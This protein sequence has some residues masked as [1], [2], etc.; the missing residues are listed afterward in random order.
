MSFNRRQ[1]LTALFAIAAASPA[2][3]QS[4]V[5]PAKPTLADVDAAAQR[6]IELKATPGVQICVR[7]KGRAVYSK[8]FGAANLEDGAKLTPQSICKIGSVTKQ[9]T[10]SLIL[11]LAE[12]GKLT[13]DDR[14]AK[15]FPDFPRAADVSLRRMLSHTSGLGNYTN[16]QRLAVAQIFRTD[17]DAA[18]IV[19]MMK[20]SEGQ[21]F[22]P[23]TAYAYSNT[24]Y[25]LLGL[26]AEKVG[27]KPYAEQARE[28]LW[29]PA[30]L[31]RTAVDN[32]GEMLPGRAAGYSID[33]NAPSGFA[34]AAYISMTVP[35]GAGFLRSTC[36]DLCLWEEALLGGKILKPASLEAMLTPAV[37]ND[38]GIPKDSRGRE[39]RYGFGLQLADT[40]GRRC[41]SHGGGIPGFISDLRNYPAEGVTIASIFNTD[42]GQTPAQ[43][44]AISLFRVTLNRAALATA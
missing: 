7:T 12:D 1:S 5:V 34:N 42:G 41:I 33:P 17:Y 20:G 31:T 22:E 11:L 37:T 38:G 24:A 28:R 26:I 8:A 3:A 40:E 2:F 19:K 4:V 9:F 6:L 15:Y 36:E 30:G 44:G 39:Q 14:L 16:G 10:A 43:L 32:V 18:R 35:G 29:G 13:I 25:V 27:G 23:G 21:V